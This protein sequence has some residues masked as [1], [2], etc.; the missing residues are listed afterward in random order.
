MVQVITISPMEGSK[1]VTDPGQEP[2]AKAEIEPAEVP[3]ADYDTVPNLLDKLDTG[4][5][6]EI[7][8]KGKGVYSY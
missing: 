6:A 5:V 7:A 1:A 3:V 4:F 8:R 2:V